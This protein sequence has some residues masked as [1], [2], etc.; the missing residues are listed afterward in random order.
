MVLRPRRL[1]LASFA[2]SQQQSQFGYAGETSVSMAQANTFK[3]LARQK[4]R[5]R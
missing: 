5:N 3:L 1:A 2:N 4:K